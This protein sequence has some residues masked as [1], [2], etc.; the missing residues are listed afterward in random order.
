MGATMSTIADALDAQGEA[1]LAGDVRY[2]TQKLPPVLTRKEMLARKFVQY[3]AEINSHK[4]P[5]PDRA[6]D[7][8]R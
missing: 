2:F 7:L 6:D 8:T 4:S 5:H 3:V 1:A